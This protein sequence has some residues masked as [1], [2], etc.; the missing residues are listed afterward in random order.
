MKSFKSITI[1]LTA[2]AA[3]VALSSAGYYTATKKQE[4]NLIISNNTN[5]ID[6]PVNPNTAFKEGEVLTYRLHYGVMDAG[7]AILEVKPSIMEISGRKV[8][9]IVGNGFSKGTFDWFYKV[10]DRYETFIDK[11]AMVPWMFVR[12]VDEGGVKFSQDYTFN[13]YTKKVDVGGGEKFDVPTGIQDMLSA[14][15][16]ARNVDFSNAKEGDIFSI[17]SF[18]DKELWPLKIKFVGREA[19]TT[20]I[21]K[22]NCLRFRPIVQK[23]RVF[24]SEEDLNIWITDDKNHVPLRAQAKIL[25]GSVKMDIT[26]A[27]GLA[28]ETSKIN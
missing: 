1:T 20:D 27:T 15:Y 14:F 13:H 26:A 11:D 23:G 3:T 7:V 28:N 2:I 10:R 21:G 4:L 18:I 17:N 5:V 25:I 9:H 16:A 22:Y 19:I 8:Y 24:K 6:L 12:R